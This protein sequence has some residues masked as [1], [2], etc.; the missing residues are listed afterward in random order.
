VTVPV[1]KTAITGIRVINEKVTEISRDIDGIR[2]YK[3]DQDLSEDAGGKYIFLYVA[4]GRDDGS[5]GP[6]ITAL[7]LWDSTDEPGIPPSTSFT[8][9]DQD[10]SEGAGGD[11][12][13]LYYSTAASEGAPIRALCVYDKSDNTRVYSTNAGTAQIYSDVTNTAGC[14]QD[15]NEGASGDYIYLM[16]SRNL[17][18]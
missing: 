17:I 13:L 15:L 10:L 18:D 2:Y 9:I 5:D 1:V 7:K 12:I 16:Y 6:P 8:K 4:F 11:F 3:I 14:R